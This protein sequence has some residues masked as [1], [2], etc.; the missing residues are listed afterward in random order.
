MQ[1]N[2]FGGRAPPRPAVGAYSAPL[3]TGRPLSWIKGGNEKGEGIRK[4]GKERQEGGSGGK[5]MKGECV[6]AHA[7]KAYTAIIQG[8]GVPLP[9]KSAGAPPRQ[10]PGCAS[11]LRPD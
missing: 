6:D 7:W 9:K 8:S 4:G 1:Q 11:V 5:R 10:I 3:Q 2:A